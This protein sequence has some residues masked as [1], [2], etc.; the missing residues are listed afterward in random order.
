MATI[1]TDHFG[2]NIILTRDSLAEK[3]PFTEVLKEVSFSH[4][5]YPGGGVTED[6]TWENGGLERMF[7]D[8]MDPGDEDYV[9]T[10]RE[11]LQFA[12]DNGSELT[13]V[14]PTFQFHDN[15]TETF[16]HDAFDAYLAELK[17]ALG[18]Y[19][20]VRI[21]DFEI[22]NEFWAMDEP[23]LESARHYGLIANSEIPALHAMAEELALEH[24]GW[25]MPGIGIQAG[26]AWRGTGVEET[27]QIAAMIDAENRPLIDTVFQHSY[28]NL[29]K[30][31]IEWQRDWALNP[32][33]AYADIDGFDDEL[34]FSISEFNVNG[35]HTTG[36]SQAAG[37]IE[38]FSAHVDMGVDEFQHWGISYKW[39]SNK[40]YDTKF[41]P[42]ESDGG[43]V[44]VKATPLGQ[45]YDL[46]QTHL[47]GKSTMEDS[48]AVARMEMNGQFGV[49]GFRDQ[50][51]RVIFLHNQ[52][53]GAGTIGLDDLPE[54]WHV[55]VHHLTVTDSPHTPWYD[56]AIATPLD[57]GKIADARADMNVAS[58][59]AA[60]GS[61]RLGPRE[62]AV[63][64]ISEPGRNLILEG[65]HN[66]TD[67]RTGTVDD[68]IHGGEGNDILRGHVG[69][70]TL[71]G[72]GG[73]NV[74]SGGKG[75]DTLIA[76][77]NGDVLVADGGQDRVIAGKGGDVILATG[78]R[79]G[80][81]ADITAGEGDDTVYV[82]TSQD[83]VIR[84]FSDG[85]A[86]G[87]GGVFE[88]ADALRAA[89]R[90]ED[91]DLLVDMP[92]GGLLRIAGGETRLDT[93]HENVLDWDHAGNGPAPM[94]LPEFFEGLSY[95][96]VVEVYDAVGRAG[97]GGVAERL[98]W[99][100]LDR[101]IEQLQLEPTVGQPF[102]PNA[103]D[104][105]NPEPGPAPRPPEPPEDDDEEGE[106]DPSSSG[107]G[108]CFV[109]TAAYG[110]G[111]HPDVIALR[112][113]R[114]RHLIRHPAGR[115]FVRLY[116]IVGPRMA[117]FTSPTSLHGRAAR[118]VLSRLVRILSRNGL[119]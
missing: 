110:C 29:D 87:L 7:G 22:G 38:E 47:V 107:G 77:D 88:N 98:G 79:E 41:P 94:A 31:H 51:Q 42:A 108:P 53:A 44:I 103:P 45:V 106:Q 113:F 66:V 76:G 57:E 19:P 70:D 85:D 60:P 68:E 18:E 117:R 9:M 5:R 55:T 16:H 95:E 4:F 10:I 83:V 78:R 82:L 6:Q 69:N 104:A 63:V 48:E 89:S 93:L 50:G 105:W 35:H 102:D 2:S 58:G 46:A 25:D 20:D 109:A 54:G 115:G 101:A 84:D 90:A 119:T 17:A 40:F 114:D 86:L 81:R 62:M 65:A 36:V 12:R 71:V 34:K 91:G 67:E 52:G 73:R 32:M 23:P 116:W 3:S 72:G 74:L 27:R 1:T 56:E 14:V 99:G 96:Q 97:D 30:A 15:A 100:S 13:I 28:P 26:A 118:A 24:E 112:R 49:T 75:D 92:G 80:D 39:L 8:P 59:A 111:R 64:I 33:K 21:R 43:D 61:I 37:W 11:A